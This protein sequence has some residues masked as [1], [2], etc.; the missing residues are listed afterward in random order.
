MSERIGTVYIGGARHYVHPETGEKAPGVTSILAQL[1]KPFLVG[2]AGKM[3]AQYAVDNIASIQD[4]ASRDP[5]AAVD[6]IK[7]ASK[8][9]TSQAANVG[10]EVHDFL[11]CRLLG[12]AP[13]PLS[14]RAQEYVP[15]IDA[16]LR[17]WKPEPILTEASV[18]GQCSEGV[19]AGSFDG[20]LKIAGETVLVD[21]KAGKSVYPDAALQLACYRYATELIGGGAIPEVDACAVIHV[22]PEAVK[23]YPVAAT[24]DKLEVFSALY[25][26]WKWGNE[27]RS[28]L[29]KPMLH[30]PAGN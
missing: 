20:I 10:T 25:R 26:V 24:R 9:H 2:W 16:W 21:W 17:E 27:S 15:A 5:E 22:R 29:G 23:V 19:Y 7:G 3:A 6:L 4:I 30:P 1:P 8:R 18:W 11:E 28:A 13:Q 12:N 14:A